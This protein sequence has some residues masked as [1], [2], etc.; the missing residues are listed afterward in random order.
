MTAGRRAQPES[1]T[2]NKESRV[3][4]AERCGKRSRGRAL[5]EPD[6]YQPNARL[7]MFVTAEGASIRWP[8]GDVAALS[9]TGPD[10]FVDRHYWTPVDIIRGDDSRVLAL[11]YHGRR[12]ERQ[13]TSQ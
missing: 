5:F 2:K 13:P 11:D 9:A 7:Q 12:G 3:F 6:F 10:K 1:L 4:S 8:S